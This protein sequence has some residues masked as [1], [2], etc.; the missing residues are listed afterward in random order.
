[1]KKEHPPAWLIAV[2]L[3]SLSLVMRLAVISLGPFHV[4]C[5]NLAVKAQNTLHHHQLHFLNGTGYPLTVLLGSLFVAL[6]GFAGNKDPVFAVNFMS[7][8]LSS[9]AIAFHFLFVKDFLTRKTAI[10]SAIVF[11]VF[12]AYLGLSTYGKSHIPSIF[13]LCLGLLILQQ[14]LQTGK[15][16]LF[17]FSIGCFGCMGASRVQEYVFLIIPVTVFVWIMFK[18]K[19]GHPSLRQKSQLFWRDSLGLW[20]GSTVFAF[21]FYV[22][23]LIDAPRT[24]YFIQLKGYWDVSTS[25][26]FLGLLS[27]SL[28]ES[29]RIIFFGLTP[30][31]SITALLGFLLILKKD[32]YK[33]LFLAVW[34][35]LPLLFLGNLSMT[36]TR[37]IMIC[38]IPLFICA[39]YFFA[40]LYSFPNSYFRL[41]S[42][43]VF[44]LITVTMF[45]NIYPVLL[46]R[47]QHA[48]L[49]DFARFVQRVTEPSAKIIAGDETPFIIYYGKREIGFRPFEAAKIPQSQLRDFQRR[50]DALLAQDTPVYIT[51]SGL[52]SYDPEK[53]FSS[54]VQNHY[55]LDYVGETLSEG[56]HQGVTRLRIGVEKLY[57]IRPRQTE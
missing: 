4:D 36:T 38:I 54:F 31:G 45:V 35:L 40:H 16:S 14:Y 57:R 51:S 43:F 23:L 33:A 41:L 18:Q 6:T 11:S 1:M 44:S 42:F 29:F 34:L 9:L 26:N 19:K 12:P 10:F 28:A 17:F 13:F 56:W 24:G 30:I 52:L 21:L 53:K 8:V 15:R 48:L 20:T 32:K 50:L 3:G 25:P 37:F 27:P 47:H 5:L 39:G 55:Q 46:F 49:P 7:V 2:I 22:P